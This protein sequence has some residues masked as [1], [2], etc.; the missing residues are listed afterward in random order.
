ME[1]SEEIADAVG[2]MAAKNGYTQEQSGSLAEMWVEAKSIEMEKQAQVIQETRVKMI[3]E[4]KTD[5]EFSGEDGTQ[6]KSTLRFAKKA[7]QS[8]PA[9]QRLMEKMK[10]GAVFSNDKDLLLVLAERGKLTSEDV[11]PRGKSARKPYSPLNKYNM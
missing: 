8:T 10:G 9:G 4:C 1:I 5:P 6:Y 3:N 11:G 2:K 7:L